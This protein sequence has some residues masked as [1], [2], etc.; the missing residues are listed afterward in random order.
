MCMCTCM[1]MM[2]VGGA[3]AQTKSVV[4]STEFDRWGLWRALFGKG[5][6][7]VWKTPVEVK[8][9]DISTFAGGLEPYKEGGN[10]TRTLHFHGK[11]GK[12][13][14]FRSTYKNVENALPQDL[15]KTL[16]GRIIQDQTGAFHPTG[17]LAVDVLERETGVISFPRTLYFLPADGLGKYAARIH[18]YSLGT[19]EE[20]PGDDTE[21]TEDLMIKLEESTKNKVDARSYLK[22]RLIDFIIGDPDRGADN[23]AWQKADSGDFKMYRAIARDRDYAFMRI[24]G[25]IPKMASKGYKKLTQFRNEFPKLTTLTFMTAEFDRS[26]LVELSKAEWDDVVH[27]VQRDL[28]NDVIDRA[29]A[30][31]PA[32]HRDLS[33]D[34]LR[35]GLRARRDLLPGIADEFYHM[36]NDDADVWGSDEDERAE[37]TH[38]ADG[39][40]DIALFRKENMRVFYK[41][42]VPAETKKVRVYLDRGNDRAVVRGSGA[43]TILVRV[44]GGEGDDVLVDSS[45]AGA[46]FY[47]ASGNNNFVRGANTVVDTR[48]YATSQPARYLDDDKNKE[49]PD[50]NPRT[51]KEE[52]RGRHQDLQ[53]ARADFVA[54]KTTAATIRTWGK[55]TTL[56]PVLEYHDGPGIVLGIGPVTTDYGFRRVPR[57]WRMALQPVIGTARGYGVRFY[58]DR[59]FETSKWSF[60]W[61]AHASKLESNRFFGFGNDSPLL[62]EDAS[63]V[64]RKE[65]LVAPAMV[66]S[67]DKRT[68]FSI[69]MIARAGTTDL[70]DAFGFNDRTDLGVRADFA[71]RTSTRTQTQSRGTDLLGGGSAYQDYREVHATGKLFVPVSRAT[72]AFRASGKRVWGD[73]PLY[74]AAFLGGLESLRG[75]WWNRFA[76]DASAAGSAELRVPVTRIKLLTRGDLGLIGFTDAGRVWYNG[77]SVGD[78]HTSFGGGVWFGSLGQALSVT[79]AKGEERRINISLGYPF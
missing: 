57:E 5:W 58:G 46:R 13:Y 30:R 67:F 70:P 59:H 40:V 69:G 64:M 3:A 54:Q 25:F 23:W 1:W 10:Q 61:Y 34:V 42:F 4:P 75:F 15:K 24:E 73:F 45:A 62:P 37:I 41:R 12:D 29:L 36:V 52:R 8:V 43:G 38:N 27:G 77:S 22:A 72:L 9:L 28:S 18:D 21:D 6:R 19:L 33:A 32:P 14:I 35:E 39:S 79:Y 60:A 47:D 71:S 68:R 53:N 55:Q 56:M 48:A 51:I 11:D 16:M 49:K 74:D 76:G 63:L 78:W 17:L 44:I 50:P 31:I 66:Y 2:M 26:H 20:K 65:L 7:D